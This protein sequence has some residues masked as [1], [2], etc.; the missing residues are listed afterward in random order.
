[1]EPFRAHTG[2]AVPLDRAD[3]DTD[4]IIPA[5][6]LKRI[7]RTGFGPFL[8]AEWRKDPSFVLNDPR[9]DGAT[10]L[11]AGANFG[12]GSSR[13]HA[14]WA[15]EDH[16]FR[17]VISERFA[18]I[19]RNNC[20]KVG[21][22]PVEVSGATVRALMDAVRAD[23]STE[24]TVDLDAARVAAGPIREGF[25]IDAFTR[26]RLLEGLDDIGLTLR[27]EDAIARFEASRSPWLP[28]AAPSA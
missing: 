18:D 1:M 3:V 11:L 12:S 25:E 16:G 5:D 17:A 4:Q 23:P 26:W 8:F 15:L 24:I 27:H 19:F 6:Y 7:E 14:V 13:E 9:Y 10:I 22:L 21:L 2:R 28:T 20:T